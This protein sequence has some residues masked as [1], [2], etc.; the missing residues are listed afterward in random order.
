MSEYYCVV[1]YYWTIN[2]KWRE[3][4]CCHNNGNGGMILS[5]IH[6]H[7]A[8]GYIQIN[9]TTSWSLCCSRPQL[10]GNRRKD[11]PTKSLLEKSAWKSTQ[12][13]HHIKIVDLSASMLQIWHDHQTRQRNFHFLESKKR[14]HIDGS[15]AINGSMQIGYCKIIAIRTTL[16]P[17]RFIHIPCCAFPSCSLVHSS[18]RGVFCACMCPCIF[19]SLHV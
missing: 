10:R 15:K 2:S 18:S 6:T 4:K 3:T 19:M 9:S 12:S 14:R 16:L 13:L 8:T 1:I 7:T 11:E 5:C 17:S